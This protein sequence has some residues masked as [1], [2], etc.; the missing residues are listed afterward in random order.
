MSEISLSAQTVSLYKKILEKIFERDDHLRKDEIQ[1]LQKEIE[2]ITQRKSNLQDRFLDGDITPQDY[3]DMKGK[4]EKEIALL[5]GRLTDLKE[6]GSPYTIYISKTVPMLEDLMTFYRNSNGMTKKKILSCI[7]SEKI[8]LDKGRVATR[9]FTPPIEIL[10]NASKI[11]ENSK[12]R[13][14]VENDLLSIMAPPVGL[15]PTTL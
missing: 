6:K 13:Q 14:E 4:V 12:N 10:F 9:P 8:V 15:E 7:F 5:K 2:R 1:K 3:Q 11:L